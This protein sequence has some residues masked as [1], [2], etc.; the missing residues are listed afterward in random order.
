[1]WTKQNL[2][3][4]SYVFFSL[5]FL[6]VFLFLVFFFFSFSLIWQPISSLC[7][8]KQNHFE[9]IHTSSSSSSSFGLLYLLYR[10]KTKSDIRPMLM[11][12]T[13]KKKKKT[14]NTSHNSDNFRMNVRF[15][16]AKFEFC[17]FFS[18]LSSLFISFC[19]SNDNNEANAWLAGWLN[20]GYFHLIPIRIFII[21]F[22]VKF[23]TTL[24]FAKKKNLFPF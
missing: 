21:L 22:T 14:R 10:L 9:Y 7:N 17:G 18:L 5:F 6:P 3:F 23:K 12:S 20:Y 13:E 19:Y 8:I 16:Q 24:Y 4:F 1:M 11:S 15:I 2:R